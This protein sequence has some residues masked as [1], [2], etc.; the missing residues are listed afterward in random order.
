MRKVSSIVLL[1]LLIAMAVL[2]VTVPSSV[3]SKTTAVAGLSIGLIVLSLVGERFK[4][5]R[6]SWNTNRGDIVGDIGSFVGIFGVLDSALKLLT[7]LIAIAVFGDLLTSQSWVSLPVEVLMVT[8]LIELGAWV[9]HWL[10]HT[11][12]TLWKLHA[13]HHSPERLYTL[14]NFRFHPLNHILNTVAIVFVPLLLGFSEES[15]LMYTAISTPVLVLQH[16]NIDLEF[17]LLNRLVNTNEVHRWHHS[18]EAGHE[19]CNLGRALTIWDQI[20]GTFVTPSPAGA[21]DRIGLT[22]H[23]KRHV[24]PVE[25][26]L[27]QLLYPFQSNGANQ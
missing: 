21:P 2:A 13:M 4:P 20:F 23:S 22:E 8:L 10:H 17:G 1:F 19:R 26:P 15:I 3:E 11:Q 6:R 7:P 9:V 25:E 18:T 5:F 16:S 14:N 27:A 12:S 24:P